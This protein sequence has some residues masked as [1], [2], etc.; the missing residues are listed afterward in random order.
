MSG[1]GPGY[2]QPYSDQGMSTIRPG[3]PCVRSS[4]NILKT[5]F[6]CKSTV[7]IRKAVNEIFSLGL[8]TNFISLFESSTHAA[9]LP[10]GGCL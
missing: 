6:N 1:A 8:N 5:M 3:C 4:A 10:V 7:E 2:N 9:G